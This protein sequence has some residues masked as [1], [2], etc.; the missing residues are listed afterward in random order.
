MILVKKDGGLKDVFISL[1]DLVF[2]LM[3]L[4]ENLNLLPRNVHYLTIKS[5]KCIKNN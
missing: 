1:H 4:L 5:I 3:F 2:V